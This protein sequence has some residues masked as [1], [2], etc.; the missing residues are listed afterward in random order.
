M[1]LT[2]S[3]L[4]ETRFI[5]QASVK[6]H[7]AGVTVTVG[8]AITFD[9]SAS[10]SKVVIPPVKVG[11][12]MVGVRL[13]QVSKNVI[14]MAWGCNC[15]PLLSVVLIFTILGELFK[16]QTCELIPIAVPV[17]DMKGTLAPDALSVTTYVVTVKQLLGEKATIG[18]VM[19]NVD[20]EARS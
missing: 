6:A 8:S 11:S 17:T 16:A 15:W 3:W 20:P 7:P 5:T 4:S 9:V 19:T 18:D 12:M 13:E 2:I 10:R 14:V 1:A